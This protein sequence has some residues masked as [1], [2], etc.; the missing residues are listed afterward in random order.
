[1]FGAARSGHRACPG[2][3][4]VGPCPPKVDGRSGE[5]DLQRRAVVQREDVVL[6]RL[7]EPDVDQLLQ[8]L[9]VLGRRSC[10]SARSSSVWNSC[11]RSWSKLPMPDVGPWSATAFQ[12]SC[13]MPR[14]PS[15]A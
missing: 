7:G 1:M 15:I 2:S 14:V 10:A 6:A 4:R 9:G 3:R 13:Q 12:P 11:H 5:E 8:L